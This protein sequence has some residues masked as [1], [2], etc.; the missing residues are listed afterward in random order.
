MTKREAREIAKK[1]LARMKTK[2]WKLYTWKNPGQ[3][4]N[5]HPALR[6]MNLFLMIQSGIFDKPG[7]YCLLA[8]ENPG[9]AGEQYWTD[10]RSFN[11]PNDAVKFQLKLA[12]AFVAKCDALIAKVEHSLEG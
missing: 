9:C 11:E 12:K 1:T 7:F 8:S 10:T 3:N 2:G 6:N 5:W 4:S